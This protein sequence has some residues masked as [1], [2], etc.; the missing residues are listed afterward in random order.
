MTVYIKW[1]VSYCGTHCDIVNIVCVSE[2]CMCTLL[3]ESP[4]HANELVPWNISQP[5]FDV[6]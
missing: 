1:Q 3:K 2:R 4:S 6:Q 5:S